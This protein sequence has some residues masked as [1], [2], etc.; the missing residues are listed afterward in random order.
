[1]E[2]FS[3]TLSAT[4]VF[5]VPVVPPGNTAPYLDPKPERVE[6]EEGPRSWV[7]SIADDQLNLVTTTCTAD[8]PLRCYHD[9][10]RLTVRAPAEITPGVY[11]AKVTLVDDGDPPEQ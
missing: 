5:Q 3:D 1:M 6:L 9:E 10:T 2:A 4:L 11:I 8:A 7:F